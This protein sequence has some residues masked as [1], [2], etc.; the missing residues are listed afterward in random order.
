MIANSRH[1]MPWMIYISVI[2]IVLL[3]VAVNPLSKYD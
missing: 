2:T 3:D 1:T